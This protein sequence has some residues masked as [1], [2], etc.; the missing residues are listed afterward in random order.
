MDQA[1]RI[2]IVRK[3]DVKAARPHFNAFGFKPALGSDGI[4]VAQ[5]EV[6]LAGLHKARCTVGSK[7]E[8]RESIAWLKA[9]GYGVPGEKVIDGK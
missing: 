5:S 8:K 2:R 3:L 6:I 7:K 4:P 1:E 9:H